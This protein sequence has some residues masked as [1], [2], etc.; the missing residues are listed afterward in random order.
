MQGR[1]FAA[2]TRRSML[3]AGMWSASI[4]LTFAIGA[5]APA[6]AQQ[7]SG[8]PIRIGGTLALTGP[9]AQTGA[10]HKIVGD[11]FVD[12]LNK[13]GGLL[14]RPVEWVLLDDQSK[15]DVTRTLYERLITVDKVDLIIG[16]YATASILSAMAVAQRYDKILVHSTFG[17]PKL[18]TYE[19]QFPAWPL[20][21]EPEK[22][23]PTAALD[24]LAST[25]K[26]PKSIAVVT[27]KFPSVQYVAAG[28]REVAK[29]RGLKEALYLEFEFGTRD[30]GPIAARVREADADFL[31]VGAIGL[32][33]NQLL[34][35]LD[36][37]N[38]KPRNHFYVYPT[39]GPM[40]ASPLGDGALSN[41]AFENLPPLNANPS[42]A[43][44]AKGFNEAAAKAGLPYTEPE[45][46][47][48]AS[49]SSWEIL[50]GAVAATKSL[51]DKV[52]TAWLKKN[53]ADTI[54]G[55][56]SFDGPN[57]Y[58]PDLMRIKQVQ[59]GKWVIIWPKDIATPGYSPQ[60]K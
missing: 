6:I 9:L 12:Q 16:P 5:A 45:T 42:A 44:F 18:A 3:I 59:K 56:V 29:S 34:E 19:R 39:P 2:A 4:G 46:Q 22:G 32:E 52:L 26:G 58:G 24:A 53:G 50:T 31:F 37:L 10:I 21:F 35:A 14:G 8:P 38:Y 41:T 54:I 27:S 25:G 51:D 11:L 30:F 33:G 13:K 17:I 48:G 36:K 57:N 43:A 47:A 60:A 49:W 15:P 20:G 23:M 40:A 1:K 55:H 7:P 28:A